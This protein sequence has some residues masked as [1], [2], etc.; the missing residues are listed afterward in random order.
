MIKGKDFIGVGVI[1]FT[2]DGNGNVLLNKR[3]NQCR[4]EHGRWDPGGGGVKFGERLEDALKREMMEEY[5]VEPLNIEYLGFREVHRDE[6]DGPTHWMG[7]DFR[8]LVDP[9]KVVNNEPHKHEDMRWFPFD[10]L[11]D[12][13]HSQFPEFIDLYGDIIFK[14]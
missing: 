6:K 7:F 2:H 5:C 12:P 1:Y 13:L 8:V 4:D 11:P 3:S 10:S 9:T 14:R